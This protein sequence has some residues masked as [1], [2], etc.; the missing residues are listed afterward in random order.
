MKNS[1]WVWLAVVVLFA[2]SGLGWWLSNPNVDNQLASVPPVPQSDVNEPKDDHAV[3]RVIVGGIKRPSSD[4]VINRE[5]K[6]REQVGTKKKIQG[7]SPFLTA[8]TNAQVALVATALKTREHPE[9]FSS[10]V[11][12]SSFNK[13][14]FDKEPEVYAKEYAKIVEPGRVFAPASPASGTKA[15]VAKSSRYHRVRQ[16]ETVRLSVKAIPSAPVTFTSF[17]LGQ[18]ENQLTSTTVVAE[19]DG[20]A[21]ANFTA[22]GG[23]INKVSILA[24]SPVTT[25]QVQFTVAVTVPTPRQE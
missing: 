17:D 13:S 7:H 4:V 20:V 18:F 24:A 9:R 15:I 12:P 1:T 2:A 14:D 16:G 10:F 5:P 19:A 3:D 6:R 25:G 23:T 8:D 11:I 21:S 22:S